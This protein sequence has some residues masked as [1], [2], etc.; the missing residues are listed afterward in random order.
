MLVASWGKFSFTDPIWCFRDDFPSTVGHAVAVVRSSQSRGKPSS[1]NHEEDIC[2]DPCHAKFVAIA[3]GHQLPLT[4]QVAGARVPRRPTSGKGRPSNLSTTVTPH[5]EWSRKH[6]CPPC[7]KIFLEFFFG[8]ESKGFLFPCRVWR[9]WERLELF[10]KFHF[11]VFLFRIPA[12]FYLC[13]GKHSGRFTCN[14][15]R[16]KRAK[17]PPKHLQG[18]PHTW[19]IHLFALIQSRFENSCFLSVKENPAQYE[20]LETKINTPCGTTQN[21]VQCDGIQNFGWRA[22]AAGLPSTNQYVPSPRR[23]RMEKLHSRTK[24]SSGR[25]ELWPMSHQHTIY[26]PRKYPRQRSIP[27]PPPGCGPTPQGPIQS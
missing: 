11:L 23:P 1:C 14:L 5:G 24:A 27:R 7:L 12:D 2:H 3:V 25:K 9:V 21:L 18:F 13:L 20:D 16:Q 10:L 6:C 8:D 15:Q 4:H 17:T 19:S 26:G 22:A